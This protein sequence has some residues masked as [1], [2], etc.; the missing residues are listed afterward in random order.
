MHGPRQTFI[1]QPFHVIDFVRR[2][3]GMLETGV[4]ISAS[5]LAARRTS[6]LSRFSTIKGS[7]WS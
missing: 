1:I 7:W 5:I 6:L 4:W 2:S 3:P